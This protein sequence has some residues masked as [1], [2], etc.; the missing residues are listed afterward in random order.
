MGRLLDTGR[1]FYGIAMCVLGLLTVYFGEFPYMLIPRPH[2]WIPALPIVAGLCGTLLIMAGVCI[3]IKRKVRP[4][5]LNIGSVLLLIFC[6]YFVPH[7]F[8][9]GEYLS[10][11]NWENAMKELD[12]CLGAFIV[13]GCFRG[14]G[15]RPFFTFQAKV[16]PIAPI[17]FSVTIISYGIIHFQYANDVAD[18]VPSWVPARLFWAYFCGAALVG[19]G[20]AIILKIKR[21][22]AAALLGLMILSWFVVLHIPRIIVSPVAYVGSEIASAMLALAYC[23]IAFVLAGKAKKAINRASTA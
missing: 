10:L 6:V 11:V 12:L 2:K 3:V 18:Y 4:T 15:E 1:I 13:A 17:L 7:Q 9:T 8:M 23:G 21:R 22:L 20:L 5:S 19:A 14:E 16:I